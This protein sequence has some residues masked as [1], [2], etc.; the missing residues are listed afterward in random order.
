MNL[1]NLCINRRRA[2]SWAILFSFLFAL[3]WLANSEVNS[4]AGL[5]L[6]IAEKN[7]LRG[8]FQFSGPWEKRFDLKR[9]E[10]L[11]VSVGL[12]RPSLLP[13]HGR[14][15]VRWRLVTENAAPVSQNAPTGAKTPRKPEAFGIYANPTADWK[16]VLHALDPD[17]YLVYRVPVT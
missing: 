16:K 15:G 11:E 13:Q 4:H 10:T 3:P 14:V 9:G 5:T 1:M 8:N 6:P 2:I 12:P 17:I 7:D